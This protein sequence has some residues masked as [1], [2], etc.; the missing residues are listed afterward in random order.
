MGLFG[1]LQVLTILCSVVRVKFVAL[2]IGATGLGLFT[3]FNSALT[4]VSTIS[5]LNLRGSSVRGIA[6]A[7]S[8][9]RNVVS[10]VVRRWGWLLGIAGAVIMVAVAPVQVLLP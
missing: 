7:P 5:Q 2:W 1:S 3:I 4:L 10:H 9:R 8:D 6:S